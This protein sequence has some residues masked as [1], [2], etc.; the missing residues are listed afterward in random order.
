MHA[1]QI[2]SRLKT[3]FIGRELYCLETVDSTNHFARNLAENG[4]LDGTIVLAERQTHGR[5]RLDRSWYSP[6]GLGLWMSIILRPTIA[7]VLAP[8]LSLVT[9]LALAKTIE[10]QLRLAAKLRWPNDCLL[11]GKKTAGILIDLAAD[12]KLV[13]FAVV[14]IGINVAHAIDDFPVELR[15]EATS[16]SIAAGRDVDRVDIL[17]PFL[18]ELESEYLR[19]LAEGLAP[20]INHYTTRC[21]L[22]GCQVDA[23]VG[24]KIISGTA[25]GIASSGGLVVATGEQEIIL[26]AGEVIRVR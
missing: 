11:E 26:T 4:A 9:A 16:L 19:F 14:G 20:I 18:A 6:P 17:L 7:P 1:D 3:T 8:G 12:P 2:K 13:R 21:S 22:I 24:E 25:I 10:R 5:G 15:E 23:L